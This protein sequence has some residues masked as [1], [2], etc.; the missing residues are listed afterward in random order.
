MFPER[1]HP[2]PRQ[3][4]RIADCSSVGL[5]LRE[6]HAPSQA[7]VC[8][9]QMLIVVHA[10]TEDIRLSVFR[11][12]QPMSPKEKA[13]FYL[14]SIGFSPDQLSLGHV[15]L[16]DYANPLTSRHVRLSSLPYAA[17]LSLAG[18]HRLTHCRRSGDWTDSSPLN[19]AFETSSATHLALGLQLPI[20]GEAGV[21][22]DSKKSRI[23]T[24]PKGRRVT[25]KQWGFPLVG[26]STAADWKRK[27]RKVLH[28]GCPS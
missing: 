20:V 26:P 22:L 19:G 21:E 16:K 28:R 12:S 7:P 17:D 2:L 14:Y 4:S 9:S 3:S 18:Y 11:R 27:A 25:L 8:C 5:A 24:S 10:W 15:V 6:L 1:G 23:V 13:T